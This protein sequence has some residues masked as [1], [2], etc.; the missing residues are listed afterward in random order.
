MKIY[1]VNYTARD[2]GKYFSGYQNDYTTRQKFFSTFEKAKN[3]VASAVIENWGKFHS[4]IIVKEA[5]EGSICEIE[6]E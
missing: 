3:F 1:M 5:G 4:N 6:I 2:A